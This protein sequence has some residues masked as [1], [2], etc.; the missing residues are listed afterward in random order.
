MTIIDKTMH[1]ITSDF[2]NVRIE[3]D[4]NKVVQTSAEI[5]DEPENRFIKIY[6][7]ANDVTE[8]TAS[9]ESSLRA[10][11]FLLFN[12]N[13]VHRRVPG[14]VIYILFARFKIP[15]IAKMQ[16]A[17][18]DKE[19]PINEKRFKTSVTPNSEEHNAINTPTIKAYCT[20]EYEK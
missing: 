8:K 3:V 17:T 12:K 5:L 10:R 4:P 15:A 6:P 7:N 9:V 16:N 2:V 18:C 14:S 13:T 1:K 11:P 20:K 19:S